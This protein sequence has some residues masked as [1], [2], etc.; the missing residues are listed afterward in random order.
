MS[1]PLFELGQIV[2]TPGG[3]RCA[4]NFA[5]AKA[6]IEMM[7]VHQGH[8]LKLPCFV[9]QHAL[10]VFDCPLCGG[11]LLRQT[12]L[13]IGDFGR[14][15][16]YRVQFAHWLALK[17]LH[18]CDVSFHSLPPDVGGRTF[19]T[20]VRPEMRGNSRMAPAGP[21]RQRRSACRLPVFEFLRYERARKGDEVWSAKEGRC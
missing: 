19:A 17:F 10:D 12:V 4:E 18:G 13:C 5:A 21:Q 7:P 8:D 9:T 6:S 15:A 11:P 2:A 3:L 14:L 1:A 16:E 20:F